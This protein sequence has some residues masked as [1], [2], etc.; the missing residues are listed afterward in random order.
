MLLLPYLEQNELYKRYRFD[1]PWDGP[2][3]R[4]LAALMPEVF[5][6]PSHEHHLEEHGGDVELAK[7]HTVYVAIR[8]HGTAFPGASSS[9]MKQFEDGTSNSVLVFEWVGKP[10]HWMDPRDA[11]PAE[12]A[13]L[14]ELDK[15]AE[16][17]H[18]GGTQALFGDGRV[19][20]LSF[21]V[22]RK[23]LRA[24]TTIAGGDELPPDGW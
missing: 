13:R 20:F 4:K 12:F 7:T 16:H 1:E 24:L 11:S 23:I 9:K 18:S 22:S 8:G 5:R 10:V 14:A 17:H 15:D 2:N 3:N 19:L 6:C 21:G